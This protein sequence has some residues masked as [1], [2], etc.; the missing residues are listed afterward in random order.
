[1]YERSMCSLEIWRLKITIIITIGFNAL[2]HDD[3]LHNNNNNNGYF[4]CYF[5]REHIALSHKIRKTIRL[6]ALC[7]MQNNI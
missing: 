5:S 6:K 7:K 1:M 4:K 2:V 3:C